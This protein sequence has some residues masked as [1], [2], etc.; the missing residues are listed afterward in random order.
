MNSEPISRCPYLGLSDDPDTSV[1]YPSEWNVCHK[2]HGHP[3]PNFAHQAEFCLSARHD[4]CEVFREEKSAWMPGDLKHD[5]GTA[6]PADPSS[7]MR[8][9]LS[10]SLGSILIVALIFWTMFSNQINSMVTDFTEPTSTVT[11]VPTFTSTPQIETPTAAGYGPTLTPYPTLTRFVFVPCGNN[12]DQEFGGEQK[13]TVHQIADGDSVDKLMNPFGVTYDQ[14]QQVNYFVPKPLW[15]G[16]PLI[17]PAKS[18]DFEDSGTYQALELTV[19]NQTLE[20]L[21]AELGVE[22]VLFSQ[23]NGLPESCNS[24]SGW[25]IVPRE[26]VEYYE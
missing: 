24:F 22:P 21:S 18:N 3:S 2:A 25:F 14:I 1:G 6:K 9:R 20:E 4:Q 17:I 13:F 19:S 8:M 7:Q 26:K 15:I 11:A 12:L 5:G 16:Y 23:L 10:A